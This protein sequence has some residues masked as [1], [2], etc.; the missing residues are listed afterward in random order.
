MELQSGFE[1]V[2][3][4][5]TDKWDG[6]KTEDTLKLPINLKTSSPGPWGMS[7][8]FDHASRSARFSSSHTL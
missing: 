1:F 5:G 4:I 3:I 2:Q 7:G 8:S 6:R